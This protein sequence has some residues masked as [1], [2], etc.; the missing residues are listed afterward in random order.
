MESLHALERIQR[1]GLTVA[2][3][4]TGGQLDWDMPYGDA[5]RVA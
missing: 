1:F 3:N 2:K 4:A 5:W